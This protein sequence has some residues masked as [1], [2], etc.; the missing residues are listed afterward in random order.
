MFAAA[1]RVKI[2]INNLES[3]IIPCSPR[4]GRAAKIILPA[5]FLEQGR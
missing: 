2:E 1:Q 5:F 3:E 4:A